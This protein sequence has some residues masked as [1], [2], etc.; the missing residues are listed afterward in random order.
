[1]GEFMKYLPITLVITLSS[2]LFVAL[3]INPALT[4]IFMRVK[5][6]K[7][8]RHR[9][10]SAEEIA[11]SGEKPV[12]IKGLILTFYSRFLGKALQHRMVVL[13]IS[14]ALLILYFQIW[15]LVVGLAGVCT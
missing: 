15:L 3:V 9:P 7:R 10:K 8:H 12:E 14:F 4:A 2:S 11:V 13:L 1:M 6:K 5:G